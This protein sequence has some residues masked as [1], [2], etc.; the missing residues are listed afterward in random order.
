MCILPSITSA[1]YQMYKTR[2]YLKRQH[3]GLEC[4]DYWS[5]RPAV[6]KYQQ[7]A[8]KQASPDCHAYD[9]LRSGAWQCPPGP[10]NDITNIGSCASILLTAPCRRA[11]PVM[12]RHV[13]FVSQSARTVR[14]RLSLPDHSCSAVWGPAAL[15]ASRPPPLRGLQTAR[16]RTGAGR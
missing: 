1:H 12:S 15:S 4:M 10:L 13:Q 3:S 8:P 16:I 9:L 7:H 2:T 14:R 6:W 5:I 11:A